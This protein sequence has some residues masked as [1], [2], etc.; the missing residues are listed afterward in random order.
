M[1][2]PR[3]V[4]IYEPFGARNTVTPQKVIIPLKK[5]KSGLAGRP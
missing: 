5:T 4:Y 2:P 1:Y 3:I